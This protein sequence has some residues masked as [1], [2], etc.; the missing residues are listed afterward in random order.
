MMSVVLLPLTTI[1]DRL[2]YA[3]KDRVRSVRRLF[4]RHDIPIIKR[5]RGAYFTTEQQYTALIEAM[6]KCSPSASAANSSTSVA[7]SVSA[8]KRASSKNILAAQ[9]AETLQ[10]P[11]APN[12][13]PI[14]GTKSFT[15]V[16]GG[17][18][19]ERRHRRHRQD[20]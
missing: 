4:A 2:Q 16:E 14:S 6:I 10:T 7:R 18:K 1:A 19:H 5:S 8:G 20:H 3:G 15:V 12:S 9:I 13:K 17:R 11:I